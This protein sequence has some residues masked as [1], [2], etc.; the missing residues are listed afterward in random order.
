MRLPERRIAT[1]LALAFS[2]L[3]VVL[4]VALADAYQPVRAIGHRVLGAGVALAAVFSLLGLLLARRLARSLEELD[5]ERRKVEQMKNEFISAVSHELR[6]PVTSIRA[7]LSMLA[8]GMADDLPDDTRQLIDIAHASCERLVRLINDVLDIETMESGKMEFDFQPHA[9]LPLVRAAMDGVQGSAARA[10]VVLVL[11]EGGGAASA[12]AQ[13]DHDR[14]IQVVVHL[15]SN[16]V[17]FS[18]PGGRVTVTVEQDNGQS[19]IRVADQGPGIPDAFRGR[20][21]QKFAQADASDTRLKGGT[22]LGLSICKSIVECHGGDI[23]FSSEAG[24]GTEFTV[25]LKAAA[26]PQPA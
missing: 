13:A 5:A 14:M 8:S 16:A 3:T 26:V 18:P 11:E 12:W 25:R 1:Y 20:I 6:T 15:L 19:V 9:L 21:F 10:G 17:K 23:G 22:G 24:R 2:G 7:S 4:T